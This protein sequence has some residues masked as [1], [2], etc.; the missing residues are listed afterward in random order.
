MS[1]KNYVTEKYYHATYAEDAIE[2]LEPISCVHRPLRTGAA[3]SGYLIFLEF[4]TLTTLD[5]KNKF[6]KILNLYFFTDL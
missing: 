1:C 5:V 4:L 6:S 3:F 2:N